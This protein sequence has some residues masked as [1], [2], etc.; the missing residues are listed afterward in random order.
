MSETKSIKETKKVVL[1]KVLKKIESDSESEEEII[2]VKTTNPIKK[3]SKPVIKSDSESEEEI[4]PVRKTTTKSIKKVS[5]P[6]IESDSESEEE[7]KPVK[8]TVKKVSSEE[9]TPNKKPVKK[10]SLSLDLSDDELPIFSMING[11]DNTN[12]TM[13]SNGLLK[14]RK[15]TIS[16]RVISPEKEQKFRVDA[17]NYNFDDWSDRFPDGK[18]KLRQLLTNPAWKEFFDQESAKPYFKNI[19]KILSNIIVNEPKKKIVP[20]PEFVFEAQN[21]LS[22]SEIEV[23][24]LGQD[25]YIGEEEIKGKLV[26]QAMGLSFSAPMNYPTPKSLVNIYQNLLHFDHVKTT[27]KSGYLMP[28]ALQGVFMLNS[29]LTT[30]MGQSN[31][32]QQL[33]TEYTMN[34]IKYIGEKTNNVVF[35]A[36]GADAHKKC[37]LINPKNHLVITS[38][39]PSPFAYMSTLRGVTFDNKEVTFSSFKSTDHFGKANKYL[40]EHGRAP[41]DWN[42]ITK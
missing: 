30:F 40:K 21:I 11:T 34:L 2:P 12:S 22:P 24:I 4:K 26:P 33:W 16:A 28:W 32:H 9:T 3:V 39:H 36:W 20:Y 29:A 6:V 19:E 14:S 38:S 35:L 25:P 23:V 13:D 37:R 1:K 27:P 10:S 15:T 18:V 7:I 17:N 42:A 31:A 5:K 8:K 41:I